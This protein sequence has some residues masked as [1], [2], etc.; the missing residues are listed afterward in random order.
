MDFRIGRLT[1]SERQELNAPHGLSRAA[2]FLGALLAAFALAS[3]ARGGETE[4]E[5]GEAAYD[6]CLEPHMTAGAG[7]SARRLNCEDVDSVNE[8]TPEV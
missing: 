7:A 2:R 1:V 6:V 8:L 5:P 3:C 4:S